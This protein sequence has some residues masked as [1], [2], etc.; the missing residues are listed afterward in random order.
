LTIPNKPG[1]LILMRYTLRLLTIQQFIRAAKAICVAEFVRQK[2][3]PDSQEISIGLWVGDDLTPNRIDEVKRIINKWNRTKGKNFSNDKLSIIDECP[4]CYSEITYENYRLELDNLII[5]CPGKNIEI[6]C[7]FTN[8]NGLPIY[9]NDDQVY[10][11]TPTLL[12]GTVDKFA[13][14][15]WKPESNRLFGLQDDLS[16]PELIIQDE[17]HL[18]SGPLGSIVGSYETLINGIISLSYRPP[19]IIA[20]TATISN[21]EKHVHTIFQRDHEIFP[22]LD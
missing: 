17:F 3:I 15:V 13:Q 9:I 19:K 18:I 12:L 16:N 4:F 22:H 1:T 21:A 8:R 2:E 20:S 6:K 7:P 5:Q 10:S 14:V 11:K